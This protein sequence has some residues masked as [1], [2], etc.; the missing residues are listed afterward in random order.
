MDFESLKCVAFDLVRK[1][2]KR[3]AHVVD[4]CSCFPF[5]Q[6]LENRDFRAIILFHFR[7]GLKAN[8]CCEQ[9]KTAF[10]ESS[11]SLSTGFYALKVEMKVWL[12]NPREAVLSLLR[13]QK[14]SP[15]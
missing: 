5:L 11:P 8:A 12:M 10:P 1:A 13:H 7:L 15:G 9:I 3:F 4:C 6:F 14:I 2:K